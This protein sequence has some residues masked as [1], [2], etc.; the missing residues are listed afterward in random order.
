MAQFFTDFSEHPVGLPPAGW[1]SRWQTNAETWAVV[2]S[3]EGRGSVVLR[4]VT[5]TV[6]R[7]LF[8][9]DDVGDVNEVDIVARF[10]TDREGPAVQ[11]QNRVFA[12]SG[13]TLGNEDGYYA[14][15]WMQNDPTDGDGLR[16]NGYENGAGFVA[17]PAYRLP[18]SP[19][20]WY[21]V[22][23]Q[24]TSTTQRARIWRADEPEPVE[25][26]AQSVQARFLSGFVGLGAQSPGVREWDW[27][28]VGTAGDPA[29]VPDRTASFDGIEIPLIYAYQTV[30]EFVADKRRTV[31]G[32]MRMDV[33]AVK[34]EWTLQTRPLPKAH[35][36]AILEHLR[37]IKFQAG[38]FV[39]H[40][41]GPESI[42]ALMTVAEDDRDVSHPD[43]HS[44]TLLVMEE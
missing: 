14:E 4:H 9:W 5:T 42:R 44:L 21:K 3:K 41:L 1:T 39:L 10:R 12:F 8:T 35:R 36:D 22:R 23:F 31:G 2:E 28:A 38:D 26:H 25:W 43:R 32:K 40:E 37:A 27:I 29:P 13:G 6:A 16:L 30:R 20:Q 18:L 33:V 34:R 17:A 15:M 11:L 7:R 24:A 19:N